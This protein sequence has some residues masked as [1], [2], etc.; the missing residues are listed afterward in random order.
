M[1][2]LKQLAFYAALIALIWGMV[3]ISQRFLVRVQVQPD[4]NEISIPDA[5]HYPS[6]RL[7]AFSFAQAEHGKAVCYRLPTD[8]K[9]FS[10]GWIAGLPG[11][12]VAISHGQLEINGKPSAAFT[13]IPHA[14]CPP[15]PVPADHL[16][17]LNSTHGTDSLAHGMMPSSSI[18]GFVVNFP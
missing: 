1:D 6:Y 17:V 9:P 18:N 11:D 8:D 5:E 2:M 10:F 4:F 12:T 7:S 16:L 13:N 15:M 14:D 3:L